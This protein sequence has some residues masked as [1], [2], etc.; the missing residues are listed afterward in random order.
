[1]NDIERLKQDAR[2][3]DVVG[4]VKVHIIA[5]SEIG[6][7]RL[8]IRVQETDQNLSWVMINNRRHNVIKRMT[9]GRYVVRAVPE[10]PE[11]IESLTSGGAE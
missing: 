10:A 9:R 3:S 11:P 2:K 6:R 7:G 8:R 4:H 5:Q 1:M